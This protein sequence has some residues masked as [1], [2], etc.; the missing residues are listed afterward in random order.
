M[1]VLISSVTVIQHLQIYLILH[2]HSVCPTCLCLQAFTVLDGVIGYIM[3]LSF[4]R[5]KNSSI[6]AKTCP[7]TSGCVDTKNTQ[8]RAKNLTKHKP[9]PQ[10]W[11]LKEKKRHFIDVLHTTDEH[12]N[13]RS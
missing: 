12:F 4:V 11:P 1:S 7:N 2:W 9:I 10:E 5:H 8:N 3:A 6:D 13:D